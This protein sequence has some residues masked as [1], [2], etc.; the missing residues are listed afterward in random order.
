MQENVEDNGTIDNPP[1]EDIENR[2]DQTEAIEQ[3]KGGEQREHP[4]V[5]EAGGSNEDK[6]EESQEEDG[7]GQRLVSTS[8]IPIFLM[9]VVDL[10]QKE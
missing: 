5:E 10:F 8:L 4:S 7:K 6:E 1:D 9:Y 3:G 2:M